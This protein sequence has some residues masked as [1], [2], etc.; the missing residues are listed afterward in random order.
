MKEGL[1]AYPRASGQEAPAKLT[2]SAPLI[3]QGSLNNLF[4][5]QILNWSF[6]H[7]IYLAV[8]VQELSSAANVS[9]LRDNY[10]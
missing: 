1:P 3:L 2:M 10:A 9:D 7:R 4:G 6:E 5:S 8:G